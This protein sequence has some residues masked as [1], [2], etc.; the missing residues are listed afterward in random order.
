MNFKPL[1]LLLLLI[2]WFAAGAILI[3]LLLVRAEAN[4]LLDRF[5]ALENSTLNSGQITIR[6]ICPRHCG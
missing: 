4:I 5:R 6:H 3:G 1:K 2:G